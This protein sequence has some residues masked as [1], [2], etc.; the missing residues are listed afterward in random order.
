MD[1][2]FMN[3]RLDEL[4]S[5]RSG[6]TVRRESRAEIGKEYRIVQIRNIS[7]DG[8]LSFDN[9]S[10]VRMPDLSKEQ[11]LIPGE[12]LMVAKGSKP[13]AA[14]YRQD[15]QPTV[16]TSQFFIL[17][18]R[19]EIIAEY[20]ACFLNQPATLRKLGESST[21]TSISF[22]PKEA[23]SQL[24]IPVP[25]IEIQTKIAKIYELGL[26]EQQLMTLLAGKRRQC[27]ELSLQQMLQS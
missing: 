23:L 2:R 4:A 12:V 24:C 10:A 19:K 8:H 20:L 26:K 16:A 15:D 14:V 21:G 18:P 25:T 9:S 7:E 17:R 5:I 13:R 6:F 3:V 22:L 11:L 27:M 1:L